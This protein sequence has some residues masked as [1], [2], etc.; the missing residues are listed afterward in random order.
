M[1]QKAGDFAIKILIARA[2]V[3]QIRISLGT[4]T[5]E[6]GLEQRL[7]DAPAIGVCTLTHGMNRYPG[8]RG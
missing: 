3:A 5:L 7:N 1:S 6:G 2:G 8:F 4:R